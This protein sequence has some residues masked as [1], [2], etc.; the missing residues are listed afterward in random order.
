[1]TEWAKKEAC[2]ERVRELSWVYPPS[3]EAELISLQK[4]R[5]RETCHRDRRAR[6]GGTEAD[7]GSRCHRLPR[8]GSSSLTGRRRPEISRAGSG[9][10][11]SVSAGLPERDEIPRGSRRSRG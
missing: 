7:R 1:M 3:S 11:L 10:S 9:G 6:R 4:S 2:W 8:R 5:K